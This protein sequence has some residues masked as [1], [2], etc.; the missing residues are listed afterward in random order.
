MVAGHEKVVTMKILAF[1]L[2]LMTLVF[3]LYTLGFSRHA[4]FNRSGISGSKG[5]ITTGSKFGIQVGENYET[6]RAL[7][8]SLGFENPEL[9][10]T[11]SCHGYDYGEELEPHLWFDNSWRK[12]TICIITSSNK[13]QY[14]SWSYGAGFP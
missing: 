10:K 7:M 13:V 2:G 14:V 5:R 6:S 9:T 11:G 8:I 12:G 1:V 4:E 3:F